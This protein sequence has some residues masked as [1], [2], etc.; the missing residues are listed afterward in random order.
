[1]TRKLNYFDILEVGPAANPEEI[2]RAYFYKARRH[3]PDA[4]RGAAADDA[5]A[6]GEKMKAI[7]LASEVLR[8]AEK[9]RAYQKSLGGAY[10]APAPVVESVGLNIRKATPVVTYAGYLVVRNQRGHYAK[11]KITPSAAWIKVT[12]LRPLTA[13]KQLPLRV[14][15]DMRVDQWSCTFRESLA[16]SLDEASTT[17]SV[18]V[19]TRDM[20]QRP[21]GAAYAGRGDNIGGKERLENEVS[22]ISR[23]PKNDGSPFFGYMNQKPDRVLHTQ[24]GKLVGGVTALAATAWV[25][26]QGVEALGRWPSLGVT[27]GIL[28][29]VYMGF[30]IVPVAVAL[31]FGTGWLAG[32][33]VWALRKMVAHIA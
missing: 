29:G 22:R 24:V 19:Q 9:R 4:L 8:D 23:R 20:A 3:H 10:M 28:G 27:F 1:M 32:F 25:A 26:F 6:S 17:A 30:L 33:G 13:D 7:N 14:D 5:T 12:S 11:L 18:F 2:R 16:V 31:G 15:V 21:A